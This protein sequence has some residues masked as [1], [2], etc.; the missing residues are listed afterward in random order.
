VRQKKGCWRTAFGE[1]F[2]IQFYQQN[3]ESRIF[4]LKFAKRCLPFAKFMW[5]KSSSS[6][7]RQKKPQNSV[8]E[9]DPKSY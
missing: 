4:V 3:N 5:Q 9:I 1:K 8:G 6:C 2:A 7:V